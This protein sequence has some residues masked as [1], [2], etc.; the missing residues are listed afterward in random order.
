MRPPKPDG[1]PKGRG[2]SDRALI[3]SAGSTSR[4]TWVSGVVHLRFRDL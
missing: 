2:V 4:V 1:F 3:A